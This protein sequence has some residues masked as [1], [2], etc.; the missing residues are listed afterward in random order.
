M[1]TGPLS[2]SQ[3]IGFVVYPQVRGKKCQKT[4][5]KRFANIGET[6]FCVSDIV[7]KTGRARQ[8]IISMM[9]RLIIPG[10]QIVVGSRLYYNRSQFN[11]ICK[12][13][14]AN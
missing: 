12:V 7:K 5:G 9:N 13:V 8:T 11:S 10:A 4:Y 2:F 6:F 1:L 14:N 3:L